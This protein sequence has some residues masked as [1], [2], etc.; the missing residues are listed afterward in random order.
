MKD[1]EHPLDPQLE[2]AERI[3]YLIAG[4]IRHTLTPAEHDELDAWVEASPENMQLFEEL[5]DEQK[6][7]EGLSYFQQ[8]N[9]RD[10]LKR[11][12]Q[13]IQAEARRT[14][15]PRRFSRRLWAMAAAAVLLA[16][17]SIL[18]FLNTRKTPAAAAATSSYKAL[19]RTASGDTIWL[20]QTADGNVAVQGNTQVVKN[21]GELSYHH[22]TR[23]GINQS[24]V[25]NTLSTRRG[26]QYSLL[27]PDGSKVWLNAA[28]S[29]SFPTAFTGHERKVVLT[30]EA[31]FE[32]VKDAARPFQ[33]WV[34]QAYVE[35]TGTRFDVNA[36]GDEAL[37]RISLVEGTVRL[38]QGALSRLLR[39]G[40]EARLQA[41]NIHLQTANL[42]Q[43]TGWREGRLV[44]RNTPLSTIA[45]ELSRWYDEDIAYHGQKD[46]HI[47]ITINRGLPLEKL[48][49]LLEATGNVQFVKS[50]QGWELK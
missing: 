37:L 18:L 12:H 7:A 16:A 30:G 13:K 20:D 44:F 2:K 14:Q 26:G 10:G 4:F 23:M 36:Y 6:S 1:E 27:L 33:V 31:F 46:L 43:A 22:T 50:G 47:S 42:A 11:L 29:I 28:S 15:S 32:V 40:E 19:L 39:P 24:T 9:T 21:G 25:M 3:A 38:V 45:R 5:T 49:R 35:A 34:G 8:V 17:V 41:G 48:G